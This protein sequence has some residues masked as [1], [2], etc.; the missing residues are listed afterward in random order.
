MHRGAA[1]RVNRELEAGGA[2][3]LHID[4]VA[5]VSDV[6]QDEVVPVRRVRAESSL[7]PH[8]FYAGIAAPQKVIGAVL[9]PP[10]HVDIGR[11]SVSRVVLEAAVLRRVMR[12]G[13]D[14]AVGELL[15]SPAIVDEDR[16]RD[17]RRRR[18]PVVLLDD[19]VH[20][21]GGED[22]ER[23]AL[24]GPGKRVRIPPHEQRAIGALQAPEVADGLGDGQNM[25]FVERAAQRRA[26]MP[27][28]PE[29]HSLFGVVEIGPAFE[30]FAFEA[31]QIDQHLR[32]RRLAGKGREGH[33]QV[34]VL[35]H[36]TRLCLPD[37][38][39]ILGDRVVAG[40]FPAAGHV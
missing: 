13:D 38:C 10:G 18:H 15:A 21:V 40:E 32:G 39:G 20:A 30:I 23:R 7:E 34:P 36:R 37:F 28:G 1:E 8:P 19:G 4:D 27:A 12:R 29:A 2:N 35:W 22:F 31:G 16:V 5:Q 11:T 26:A 14:N 17:D 33:L 6:R 24:G 9:D 25:G 3:G